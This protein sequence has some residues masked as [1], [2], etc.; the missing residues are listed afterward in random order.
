MGG[1]AVEVLSGS[2][3][4]DPFQRSARRVVNPMT[5]TLSIVNDRTQVSTHG[6][7]TPGSRLFDHRAQVCAPQGV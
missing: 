7:C 5:A 6:L 3:N 4:A 1:F 2:N